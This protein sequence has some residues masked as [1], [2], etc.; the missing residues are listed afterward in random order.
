M[1]FYIDFPYLRSILNFYPSFPSKSDFKDEI[2]T[3]QMR[4]S[5]GKRSRELMNL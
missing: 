1:R 4:G 2:K 5:V 3:I